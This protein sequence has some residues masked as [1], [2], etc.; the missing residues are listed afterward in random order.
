MSAA[1]YTPNDGTLADRVVQHLRA[2]PLDELEAVDIAAKFS[3]AVGSVPTLLASC[4]TNGLIARRKNGMSTWLY[5]AGP[6]LFRGQ[7]KAPV[8]ASPASPPVAAPAAGAAPAPASRRSPLPVLDL[9]SVTVRRD[10]QDTGRTDVRRVAYFAAL[11]KLDAPKT[12]LDLDKRYR[13]AISKAAQDYVKRPGHE[14]KRFV[15]RSHPTDTTLC[16]VLREA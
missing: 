5:I 2:Q 6:H 7:H 12:A 15:F 3:C 14:G 13:G 16:T 1:D 8:Y 4:I 10:V 11:D 9:S